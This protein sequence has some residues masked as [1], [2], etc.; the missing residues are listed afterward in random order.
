MYVK[1][2]TRALHSR[3]KWSNLL[4]FEFWSPAVAPWIGHESRD[5]RL[6]GEDERYGLHFDIPFSMD[7]FLQN[8]DSLFIF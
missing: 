1:Q 8:E 2:L 3:F 7:C 4:L 5:Q 6:E